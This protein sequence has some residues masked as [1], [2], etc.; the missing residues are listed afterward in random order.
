M[1]FLSVVTIA[2]S[3][4]IFFILSYFL[5]YYTHIIQHNANKKKETN[6]FEVSEGVISSLGCGATCALKFLRKKFQPSRVSPLTR[7]K[8]IRKMLLMN[9]LP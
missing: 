6:I 1:S 4:T 8:A 2:F 3:T 9:K 5:K 7:A